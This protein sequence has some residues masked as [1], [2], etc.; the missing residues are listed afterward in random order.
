MRSYDT[1]ARAASKTTVRPFSI[2]VGAVDG[3]LALKMTAVLVL[4]LLTMIAAGIMSM[5]PSS[6]SQAED[7]TSLATQGLAATKS[8]RAAVIASSETC[9]SQAWGAWTE[10]C[11]AALSGASKVR[12]VSFVTV[13]K[14]SPTV[15]ET[16]LYRFPVTN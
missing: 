2:Q 4:A 1:T 16:I 5:H 10:D 15:N 9:K 13:E 3:S 12:K 6:A 7:L 11:A 8:D 14:A